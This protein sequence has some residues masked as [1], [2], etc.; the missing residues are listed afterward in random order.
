MSK[1]A[2]KKSIAPQE[3]DTLCLSF[4]NTLGSRSVEN[5]SDYLPDYEGLITWK[6]QEEL[7]SQEQAD[8]LRQ[9]AKEHPDE[10]EAIHARA[11]ELREAIFRI[12]QARSQGREL[13]AADLDA[14]NKELSESWRNMQLI[15]QPDGFGCGWPDSGQAPD[16]AL[17]LASHSAATLLKSENLKRVKVCA[18]PT[19][20]WL[21]IDASKNRSRR[22]CDMASCGNRAKARR[23]YR[24]KSGAA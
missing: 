24:K 12:F 15:P 19:C 17:W 7:I 20:D 3:S 21:F 13:E 9:W 1:S 14:L 18:S 22:W 2:E 10:A 16:T 6:L 11:V 8:G 5:A 4:S 23:Y